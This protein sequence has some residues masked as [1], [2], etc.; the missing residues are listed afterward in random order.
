M[1]ADKVFLFSL[2][3]LLWS[4]TDSVF[5]VWR[6]RDFGQSGLPLTDVPVQTLSQALKPIVDQIVAANGWHR[7]TGSGY[8][9]TVRGEKINCKITSVN[10]QTG[11]SAVET[12]A[13]ELYQSP[14]WISCLFLPSNETQAVFLASGDRVICSKRE[15]DRLSPSKLPG[16]LGS[17]AVDVY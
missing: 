17:S 13:S 1:S 9:D 8:L 6:V 12:T 7:V 2:T 16:I 10:E 4:Q 15:E 3:Q 11:R 5:R 14:C